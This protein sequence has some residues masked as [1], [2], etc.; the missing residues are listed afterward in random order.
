MERMGQVG[1]DDGAAA[2]AM[3][4]EEQEEGFFFADGELEFE[5]GSRRPIAAPNPKKPSSAEIAE[6][7]LTHLPFRSWFNQR[8]CLGYTLN[9]VQS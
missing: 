5:E 9:L 8:L 6:H 4:E 2:A 1:T 3:A 7:E